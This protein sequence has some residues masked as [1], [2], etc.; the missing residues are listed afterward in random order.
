MGFISSV[1]NM[2]TMVCQAS[3]LFHQPYFLSGATNIPDLSRMVPGLD[4]ARLESKQMG[5]QRPWL[6][7]ALRR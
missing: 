6:Q 3:N 4:V 7:R 2:L 1:G 5:G